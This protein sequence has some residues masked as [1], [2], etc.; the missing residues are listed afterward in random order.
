M[1]PEGTGQKT[2]LITGSTDGL[3]RRIAED[4]ASSGFRVLLHGRNPEK[5]KEILEAITSAT[6]VD[7]FSYYYYNA[8]FASLDEVQSLAAPLRMTIGLS[9]FSSTTPGSGSAPVE[10][11][12]V[13]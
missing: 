6:G 1:K 13:K 4:L 7:N 11:S 9:T 8:N 3:G 10:T 2:I 12:G 5:G